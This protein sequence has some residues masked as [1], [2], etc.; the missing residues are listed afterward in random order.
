MG[1]KIE[2]ETRPKKTDPVPEQE[3]KPHHVVIQ[4][5]SQEAD[6][7]GEEL[8]GGFWGRMMVLS[9]QRQTLWE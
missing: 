6:K 3:A 4:V 8:D 1:G 9:P 7:K 5:S 2:R